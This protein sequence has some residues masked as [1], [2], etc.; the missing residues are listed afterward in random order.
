[1]TMPAVTSQSHKWYPDLKLLPGPYN[2]V[3]LHHRHFPFSSDHPNYVRQTNDFQSDPGCPVQG[4][5]DRAAHVGEIPQRY[6]HKLQ[7]DLTSEALM[8]S[9]VNWDG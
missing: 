7:P 2:P 1:M 8:T 6:P 3:Q 4:T 9:Q 5:Q